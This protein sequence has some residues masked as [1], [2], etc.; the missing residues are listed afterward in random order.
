MSD[1]KQR[2]IELVHGLFDAFLAGLG[3]L[4]VD[5]DWP[6]TVRY[7]NNLLTLDFYYG[8]PEYRVEVF[9]IR[10]Q[11]SP[12]RTYSLA[13]LFKKEEIKQWVYENK[14][15]EESEDKVKQGLDWHYRLL[16]GCCVDALKGDAEFFA[17]M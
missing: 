9:F 5:S 11:T 6:D 7:S 3:L 10:S 15:K 16:Q 17:G 14:P 8:P 12:A 2:F 4:P 13:D 1:S